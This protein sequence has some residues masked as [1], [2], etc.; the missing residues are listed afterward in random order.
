MCGITGIYDLK[1]A[2]RVDI[3]TLLKMRDKLHHRGP[4]HADYVA[5][6]NIGLAITRLSIIDIEHGNQPLWNED[7][8]IVLIANGE[9]FNYIELKQQLIRNGHHF[10]TQS[11]CEV[12]IHLYEEEGCHFLNRLNGQ[13]AFVIYDTNKKLLFAARDH[14]GI[15][16]FYYT[17]TKDDF[18]LFAS[19]IKALLEH[20]SVHKE[21]DLVG[22][23][24]ILTFPGLISP[25]TL[26]KSIHSLANGHYITINANQDVK[27]TEYW[28][29]I[30]PKTTDTISE[31]PES[32]YIEK[33]DQHFE[34]SVSYRL[35][36]DVPIGFYI[37]GGLDSAMISAKAM[38]LQPFNKN[39][40]AINVNS[41]NLSEAKYQRLLVKHLNTT[42]HEHWF[43]PKEILTRLK[44]V[45]YHSE[46]ALKETYNTAS[47]ALSELVN[48]A[49]IKVIL[50]GE[51]A[52]VFFA[53][54]I[55]YRF[56]QMNLKPSILSHSTPTNE[57]K[58]RHR[59]W[60]N[61]HFTYEKN[62]TDF[63]NV[64]RQLYSKSL[65]DIADSF[66][67]TNH[68][69]INQ[70]RVENLNI[71]HLRSYI[72]YKLRL[73]DHLISDHGDRMALANSVECRYPFLDKELV[74]FSTTIPPSLLVNNY[75]EKYILKKVAR[76]FVPAPIIDRDKFAFATPASTALLSMN[77]PYINDLLSYERIKREGYFDPDTVQKLRHQYMQPGFSIQVP[78]EQDLL[79]T[80]ITFGMFL[81]LFNMPYL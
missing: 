20:P 61:E 62:Y 66:E 77:D 53:G 30:Y 71:T 7:H 5:T 45:I 38:Q 78:L 17:K 40:F 8:S 29:L 41:P 19:E 43:Q 59:L 9:I 76:S 42:H 1:H 57:H 27:T 52:D 24:Q 72:D 60:G 54:Y 75:Q 31:Q 21:V 65:R 39:S 25:R 13:F 22:L 50:S 49:G 23:D 44:K 10:N 11:D 33:L 3:N 15:T 35:R 34:Q 4:D 48:S 63:K 18:F 47:I 2:N 12:L 70:E 6:D 81:E 67:A 26:F 32:Y 51:G 74:E 28:D 58:L 68:F 37:S 69:V 64:K 73:C 36:A 55:G 56:D 14:F 80:V 46:C 16:P 79:I